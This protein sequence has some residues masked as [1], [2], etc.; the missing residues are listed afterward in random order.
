MNGAQEKQ[1]FM[2]ADGSGE[3]G[4]ATLIFALLDKARPKPEGPNERYKEDGIG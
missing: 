2:G 3:Q 1:I 4:Y